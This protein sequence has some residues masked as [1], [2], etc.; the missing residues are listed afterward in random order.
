MTSALHKIWCTEDE[1]YRYEHFADFNEWLDSEEGQEVR[2]EYGVDALPQPSKALFSGDRSGYDEAFQAFRKERRHEALSESYFFEQ[3]SDDHWFQRNV[4]HFIQL[5]ELMYAGAV[6]PFVGAGV[7][8]S[9]GFSSWKDHLRRQGKTAHISSDR[10][11][12]LLASG[13]YETVLEEIEAVRGREV[14]INEIRDE[15]SRSGTI[16]D[17]NCRVR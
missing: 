9:G 15:F 6:V 8:V 1:H 5:V 14:F 2:A 17:V 10:I 16:P 13:A 3:F 11:E 7:S 4:D 12:A